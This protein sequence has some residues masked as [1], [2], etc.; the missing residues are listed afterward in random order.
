MQSGTGTVYIWAVDPGTTTVN[1]RLG[2]SLGGQWAA[3]TLI[4]RTTDSWVLIGDLIQ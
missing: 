2:A 3:C 1:S 4:K